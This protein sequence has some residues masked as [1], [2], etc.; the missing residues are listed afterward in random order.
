MTR[1]AIRPPNG[2]QRKEMYGQRKE[3]VPPLN[4]VLTVLF[5]HDCFMQG[6][7]LALTVLFVPNSLDSDLKWRP[8][9]RRCTAS[10]GNRCLP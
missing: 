7:D 5:G 8:S 9:A 2:A 1:E 4:L 6:Q 10:A 3:Q